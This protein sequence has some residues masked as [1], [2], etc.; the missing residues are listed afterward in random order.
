[1]Y[2]NKVNRATAKR[3]RSSYSAEIFARK[4]LANEFEGV[5]RFFIDVFEKCIKLEKKKQEGT[6]VI[7]AYFVA[8]ITRRCH[9][10]FFIFLDIFLSY[11][12]IPEQDWPDYLKGYDLDLFEDIVR[13]HFVTDEDLLSLGGRIADGYIQDGSLPYIIVLDELL[14]HGRALNHFLL[15]LERS[16]MNRLEDHGETDASE[17]KDEVVRMVELNIYVQNKGTLLLFSRYQNCLHVKK[18]Y[19][20]KGWKQFSRKVSVLVSISEINNVAYSWGFQ[21]P[22]KSLW[23]M[24]TNIKSDFVLIRTDL[25]NIRQDN[26]IY[27]YPNV[28]N[29]KAVCTVRMKESFVS[30]ENGE[31]LLMLVPF[32]ILGRHSFESALKLHKMLKEELVDTRFI[33]WISSRDEYIESKRGEEFY[34]RWLSETN[35]LVLCYLL[36]KKFWN[37]IAEEDKKKVGNIQEYVDYLQ[38][39][40]N[41]MSSCGAINTMNKEENDMEAIL[42]SIWEWEPEEGLL[43]K[44]LDI[45]TSDAESIYSNS[46]IQF[47]RQ[48]DEQGFCQKKIQYNVEDV[49]ASIG[50]E[51]ERNAYEKCNSG[52][53][54]EEEKLT[55]CGK[56]YSL[57]DVIESYCERINDSEAVDIYQVIAAILQAM[58]LGLIGMNEYYEEKKLF[59]MVRAGE[60][61]L[62]IRAIWFRNF[63]AVLNEINQRYGHHMEDVRSEIY[64]FIKQLIKR[65]NIVLDEENITPQKLL[66]FISDVKGIGHTLNSWDF[67]QYD[68]IDKKNQRTGEEIRV[69]DFLL[70]EMVTQMEYMTIYIGV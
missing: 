4:I 44:Y 30:A 2:G 35:E 51:A 23:N 15:K 53:I 8:L 48:P 1:M 65:K 26:Y 13:K 3:K 49:I 43:E 67:L 33:K 7:G 22:E 56:N 10:L 66:N 41:Y 46:Q 31:N 40:R 61:S 37:S 5:A 70:D 54:F 50:I 64:R 57:K 12:E 47:K 69:V 6:E 24:N 63:L 19:D 52:V 18:V 32:I 38:I 21:I 9:V 42:E 36:F 62:F 16:L 27:L 11:R 28:E 45:A 60:Q 25:Q 55:R 29:P 20:E 34:Y 17:I 68:L 14:L 39:S 58:D 59:T